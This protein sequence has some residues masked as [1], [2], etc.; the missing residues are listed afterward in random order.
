MVVQ[1]DNIMSFE[2]MAASHRPAL[3]EKSRQ[4]VAQCR[5]I[6]LKMLPPLLSDLFEKLDDALYEISE[7]SESDTQQSR[8]F[9]AMREMR[10]ARDQIEKQFTNK[11]SIEYDRFWTHGPDSE[12]SEREK[13]GSLIELSLLDEASLEED[14]ALTSLISKG[15]NC[16][17]SDLEALKQRFGYILKSDDLTLQ[18][19]PVAPA[20]IGNVYF[21]LMNPLP[22]DL[23]VKLVIYKQFENVVMRYVGSVYDEINQALRGAGIL[24]KL[25]QRVRQNPVAPVRQRA[26]RDA[27]CSTSGGLEVEQ[28]SE[29]F[30][31]LQSLLGNRA[32]GNELMLGAPLPGV[33]LPAVETADLVDTLSALQGSNITLV[34]YAGAGKDQQNLRQT[35][36]NSLQMVSDGELNKSLGKSDND[37]IDVISMVFEYILDDPNLPDPMKAL[38]GRLQ[39]PMLKIALTDK[40]FFS[41]NVHP[42]RQLLNSIARA[43]VGW[44]DDGDRSERGLYG[45]VEGMV[46]RIL[47]EFEQDAGLFEELN[48]SFKAFCDTAEQGAEA[49]EERTNQVVRGKEQLA[50]AKMYVAGE[51]NTRLGF[52]REVP[53]VVT[54][55]LNDGWKDV[56]LLLYLRKGV[57][58]E[59]WAKGLETMDSLLWSVEPKSEQAD[60]K[61]LLKKIPTL[62]RA[63]R[64][65]LIGISYDQ[66]KM[67]RLFKELQRCHILCM[68]GESGAIKMEKSKEEMSPK[69]SAT[70]AK[71]TS[72]PGAWLDASLSS[73]EQKSSTAIEDKFL[74][75]AKAVKIGTWFELAEEGDDKQRIKLSWKSEVTGTFV[76]V[77][78]RGMKVKEL[79]LDEV[80]CLLRDGKATLLKDTAEPLMDRA[81][82]AMMDV[83]EKTG[84]T[85]ATC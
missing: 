15:E 62:L 25:S 66:H 64:E 85:A 56:L 74:D 50:V 18:N 32:A 73:D 54:L 44:N 19:I 23:A 63:L 12:L 26:Y 27:A 33:S 22:I 28:H 17:Q 39:I 79:L 20:I 59:D 30:Q 8:Y 1:H 71:K 49:A 57:D 77:D 55:L 69:S 24:P 9:D 21:Q 84:P 45:V 46:K 75:Q 4:V 11:I 82:K 61:E 76:F 83:L 68:K 51:I 13:K 34:A 38:I 10:K 60:R 35:L 72:K 16:F 42:A 3:D 67:A 43:A 47:N 80:A 65:G 78:H 5:V 41:K 58:S 52:C 36:L 31:T 48:E 6:Y 40:A 70:S 14:L 53:E 2:K 81:L 29:V 7:K 37:T